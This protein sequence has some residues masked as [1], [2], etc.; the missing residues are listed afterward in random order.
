MFTNTGAFLG[1]LV[2]RTVGIVLLLILS[3]PSYSDE[4]INRIYE[5]PKLRVSHLTLESISESAV[6]GLYQATLGF[7]VYRTTAD[8]Q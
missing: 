4:R 1:K 8:D 3:V 6:G 2:G 7:D 5:Q